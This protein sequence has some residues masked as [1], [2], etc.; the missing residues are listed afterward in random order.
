MTLR[1][2]NNID[3]GERLR[4]ARE[5][6]E[7]TQAEAAKQIGVA[8][9][10][11]VAIEKGQRKA[12]LNELHEL[13]HLYEISLNSLLRREAVQVNLIPQF[14]KMSSTDDHAVYAAAE[15]M[16]RMIRAEVELEGLLGVQR[17]I[18]YP[19]ER[20]LLPGNIRAQA[21]DDAKELRSWLGLGQSPIVDLVT[22]MDL[23]LGIRVYVLPLDAKV[24]GLFAYD[25]NVGACVLANANH[26][27][28]RRNQTLA[29][30][31]GHFVGT[32]KSADVL[33]LNE[34]ENSREEKYANTFGRA[35]LTPSK[36]VI[37]KFREVTAGSDKLTRRHIII[38]A[39]F[40]GVSREAMVRRLEELR[41]TKQGTWDWFAHNGGITLEQ[42]V[43]VLGNRY[44]GQDKGDIAA[45]STNLR[46]Y[47]L[48][49]QAWRQDL[50]S[51]GQLAELLQV[52]RL[53]VRE[54][55]DQF[56]SDGGDTD[57]FPS[58]LI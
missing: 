18:N 6:A 45:T 39:Y 51:E 22:L 8:R 53:A 29:H 42:V 23:Q 16:I 34:L 15:A 35:F 11:L 2:D 40:F 32:R 9:T 33:H 48:A 47:T 10:T 14:R 25:E 44:P 49:E 58:L 27:F 57:E 30:E 50:L 4:A 3:V 5:N 13:A 7:W 37:Q 52:D 19:P 54:I 46:L 20:P 43:Q 28:E 26:P 1:P 31:L 21:E 38:L 24:A 41:L 36:L 12:R 55:L 17:A 56:G